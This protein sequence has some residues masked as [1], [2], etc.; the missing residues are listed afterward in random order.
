MAIEDVWPLFGLSIGTPRLRMRVVRDE[1]LEPLA[2]AAIAG[3]HDPDRMPFGVPWTDAEPAALRSSLAAFQWG[4]RSR[5]RPDRWMLGLAVEHEG[6]I[7]GAQDLGAED[8]AGRRTV[9]SGSWLTR[10]VQGRG[11]GTEMRAALLQLAFDHLGAEW[12]ESSAASWN[13]RSLAVS[14]K[15]GYR[16]N[17]TTRRRVRPTEVVDEVQV[18]LARADFVRPSWTA[19][20]VLPDAARAQLLAA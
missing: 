18:R 6:R 15:L 3:V 4:L 12:A 17:G 20:V 9:T 10:S 5:V 2:E 11:I 16:P 19:A 8:L 1:D 14:A 13:A 7:V